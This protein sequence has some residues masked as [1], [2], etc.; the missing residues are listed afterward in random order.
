MRICS[1]GFVDAASD[2]PMTQPWCWSV[3]R[4]A[5]ARRM[6]FAFPIDGPSGCSMKYRYQQGRT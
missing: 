2:A 5:Q 4:S 3:G 6:S 1:N